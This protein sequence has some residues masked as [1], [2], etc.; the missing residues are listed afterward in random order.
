MSVKITRI[1]TK[2]R[3]KALGE[4]VALHNVPVYGFDKNEWERPESCITR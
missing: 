1:I 3:K 2:E 4:R